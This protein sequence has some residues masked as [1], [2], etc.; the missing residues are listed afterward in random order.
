M[1][2]LAVSVVVATR[3]RCQLLPRFA[4]AVLNQLVDVGGFELVVVDDASTDA[5]WTVLRELSERDS[6]VRPYRLSRHAGPAAARNR[7]WRAARGALVAFTDDDCVPTQGWLAALCAAHAD[8]ADVVQGRTLPDVEDYWSR[9]TFSHWVEVPQFSH[10]YETCNI[11]YRRS[12]LERLGGF[13]ESF[14][15]SRGGAPNGE[16]AELGWRAAEVGAVGAFAP[17]ALVRHPVTTS[18]F[19][20]RLRSRLRSHRMVY[21]IRRHPGYRAFLPHPY[22]FQE[23][24]PLALL[25]LLGWVP[26]LVF[27]DPALLL[28]GL[29]GL[30][31]YVYFRTRVRLLPGRLRHLPLTVAGAWI[32]DVAEVAVLLAASARWRRLLI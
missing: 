23:G 30:A 22:V 9:G 5:T 2:E 27:R 3:N 7:G 24:H 4:A 18:S 32:T 12:L 28:V 15:A 21:F 6:R 25:G 8:G 13:D 29:A 16:D 10:L 14:G 17:E 19:P 26:A 1:H 20:R 31:P 11:S